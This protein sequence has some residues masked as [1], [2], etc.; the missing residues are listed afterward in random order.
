MPQPCFSQKSIASFLVVKK[1][2]EKPC[3]T[4][5][6]IGESAFLLIIR[7][8]SPRSV[9]IMIRQSYFSLDNSSGLNLIATPFVFSG[10][11]DDELLILTSLL[12]SRVGTPSCSYRILSHI[13]A[14]SFHTYTNYTLP[15]PNLHHTFSLF[16]EVFSVL[17]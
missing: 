16:Y 6:F 11:S 15:T 4:H 8:G 3:I 13:R 1:Q 7:T 14:T 17:V 9:S 12:S 5:Q 2:V 10:Y